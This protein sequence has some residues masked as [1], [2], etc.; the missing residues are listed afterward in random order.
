LVFFS[1]AINLLIKFLLKDL[2][3]LICVSDNLAEYLA[4]SKA[5]VPELLTIDTNLGV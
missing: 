3:Y 4:I 2:A 5:S 1:L